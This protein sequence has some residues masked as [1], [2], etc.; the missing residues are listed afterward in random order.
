MQI[1]NRL[2]QGH[3]R[4][5]ATGVVCRSG[6]LTRDWGHLWWWKC[7]G[8][9]C[10]QRC[11]SSQGRIEVIWWRLQVRCCWLEP[12]SSASA[13]DIMSNPQPFASTPRRWSRD[14]YCEVPNIVF[15]SLEYLSRRKLP[16]SY[17]KRLSLR[18][19]GASAAY[20]RQRRQSV[21]Y[22]LHLFGFSSISILGPPFSCY[23][24]LWAKSQIAKWNYNAIVID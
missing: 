1:W 10:V 15:Q 8:W 20:N 16:C 14:S 6:S 3:R 17:E 9:Q 24:L 2:L 23:S 13:E 21:N 22:L 12:L 4:R 18:E 19:G 7:S 5:R 11:A